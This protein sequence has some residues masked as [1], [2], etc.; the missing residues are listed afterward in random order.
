LI[1]LLLFI[2]ADFHIFFIFTTPLLR[3]FSLSP[4]W[5]IIFM[6]RHFTPPLFYAI[7][8]SDIAAMMFR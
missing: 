3:R 6:P 4:R 2:F 7:F 1:L 5:L 8:R